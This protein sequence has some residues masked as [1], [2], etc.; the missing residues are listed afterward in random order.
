MKSKELTESKKKEQIL[1]E[2]HDVQTDAAGGG[3]LAP[4]RNSNNNLHL[5]SD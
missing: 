5:I 4:K 1:I 3:L 2:A